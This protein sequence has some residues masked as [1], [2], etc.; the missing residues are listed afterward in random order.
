MRRRRNR[1]ITV[2]TVLVVGVV[3][4]SCSAGLVAVAARPGTQ[5]WQ[6]NS[7]PVGGHI[8]SLWLVP[9]GATH[10]GQLILGRDLPLFSRYP[11]PGLTLPLAPACP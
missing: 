2:F 7:P 5:A 4:I 8:Y 11:P 1:W 9:C 6:L 10:P 3:L